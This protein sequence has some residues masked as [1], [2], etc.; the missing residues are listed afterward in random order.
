MTETVGPN[1]L[2]LGAQKAG[3]TWFARVLSQQRDVFIPKIKELHFFTRY[4]G[5]GQEWYETQF[6]PGAEAG[7]RALGDAT[8]NYLAVNYAE[9]AG[10]AERI[11]AYRRD[12][13]FIVI[14]RN[15]I[16][17]ALSAYLHHVARGRFN[18]LQ[19]AEQ[20][21]KGLL[22]PG[23]NDYGI[24]QFGQYG[25]QL[26]TYFDLF[27]K[28]NFRVHVLEEMV[29]RDPEEVFA[30][31]LD[32]LGM[33]GTK[34]VG[35]FRDKANVSIRGRSAARIAG[36]ASIWLRTDRMRMTFGGGIAR[37]GRLV[38]RAVGG[39]RLTLDE[40][41][42]RYLAEYYAEDAARL[43]RLLGRDRPIWLELG[44]VAAKEQASGAPA[45]G[46]VG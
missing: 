42:R 38:D 27:P 41:T 35:P 25:M 15:P 10:V 9:Y 34:P 2:I 30:E 43:Q 20:H 26:A 37:A 11:A 5:R 17:R 40:T 14:L 21:F 6:R 24:L 7:A 33:P 13:R 18:P 29:K 44:R 23:R 32:F 8:P 45:M 12:L 4:Y 1:F 19:T 36:F 22:E 28:E 39:E 16:E 46:V 31:T 3:T